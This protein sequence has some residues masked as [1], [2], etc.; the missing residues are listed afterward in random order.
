MEVMVK[1]NF[2]GESVLNRQAS[3]LSGGASAM[4]SGV[5]CID[6]R[7]PKADFE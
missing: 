3:S 6:H 7:D 1:P 4:E 2:S 5:M